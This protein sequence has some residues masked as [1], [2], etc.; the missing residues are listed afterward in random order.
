M[1]SLFFNTVRGKC[2]FLVTQGHIPDGLVQPLLEEPHGQQK[3]DVRHER[4]KKQRE[5]P[6]IT[7][8]IKIREAHGRSKHTTKSYVYRLHSLKDCRRLPAI[9]RTLG[10]QLCA[11]SEIVER[12][13]RLNCHKGLLAEPHSCLGAFVPNLSGP[14]AT[15]FQLFYFDLGQSCVFMFF[16]SPP[17][18]GYPLLLADEYPKTMPWIPDHANTIRGTVSPSILMLTMLLIL[19]L[20]TPAAA[21]C[22]HPQEVSGVPSVETESPVQD[23]ESRFL[24]WWLI[25]GLGIMTIGGVWW[26][27]W[28]RQTN[29]ANIPNVSEP[30]MTP[31][32]VARLRPNKQWN[33]VIFVAQHHT[34]R[35]LSKRFSRSRRFCHQPI[36]QTV[37]LTK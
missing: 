11:H 36:H 35:P 37:S 31:L 12:N 32:A 8:F 7:T 4:P 22:E 15:G 14:E 26:D 25:G 23:T 17:K 5:Y 2:Q 3:N 19:S 28:R 9:G 34:V 24:W 16:L 13:G 6:G 1:T 18:G 27:Q 33:R 29:M 30:S 20:S 21:D 10:G